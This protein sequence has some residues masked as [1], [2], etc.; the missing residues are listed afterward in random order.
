MAIIEK[1][2]DFYHMSSSRE[3]S[4]WEERYDS[5][6]T[7]WDLQRVSTPLK[8]YIDQLKETKLSILVPGCGY[9]HEVKYLVEQGFTNVSV[10]DISKQPIDSLENELGDK[11]KLI[12]GDFF[13]HNDKYDLILE[14]TLFCAI[15]PSWRSKY[16][17]KCAS[18]LNEGG[19]LSGV[20]FNFPLTEQG[21]PFGGGKKEYVP[22]FSKY[23]EIDIMET[24]KNS[25]ENREEL[26]IKMIKK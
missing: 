5:N 1:N 18:L 16:V 3:K 12:C 24:C 9:G 20:L 8:N 19:K 7:G 4:F 23:F 21:P 17:E 13:T 25:D 2:L 14:Q 22:L 15:P 10:I 11:C 6:S 26:F